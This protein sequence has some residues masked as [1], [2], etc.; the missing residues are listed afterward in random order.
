VS[1]APVET[2]TDSLGWNYKR[3][4]DDG[5]GRRIV[6]LEQDGM[7]WIGIR[8]WNGSQWLNN[9]EPEKAQVLCW[10]H[11]PARPLRYWDHGNL[12]PEIF[13]RCPR[14]QSHMRAQLMGSLI[15]DRCGP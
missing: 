13:P 6:W 12:S 3:P 11:L 4:S 1:D 5:D 8:H 2:F 10:M 9:N 14:C 15:C 7:S